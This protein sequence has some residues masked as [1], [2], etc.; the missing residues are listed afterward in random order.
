VDVMMG[1]GMDLVWLIVVGN[2]IVD[3]QDI[4]GRVK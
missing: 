4:G 1:A 2:C 3:G